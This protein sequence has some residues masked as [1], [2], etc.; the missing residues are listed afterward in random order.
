MTRYFHINAVLGYGK[1]GVKEVVT[2]HSPA[3]P[4]DAAKNFVGLHYPDCSECVCPAREYPPERRFKAGVNTIVPT[5]ED[6]DDA[7]L[8]S[9]WRVEAHSQERCVTIWVKE[10]IV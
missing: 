8:W 2:T 1:S 7:E 3:G 6:Y 5:R 4:Y 10:K 9:V